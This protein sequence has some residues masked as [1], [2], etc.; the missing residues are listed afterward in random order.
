MVSVFHAIRIS[1]ES[2]KTNN[3]CVIIAAMNTPIDSDDPLL[4]RL[5]QSMHWLLRAPLAA[6]FLYHG[7]EKWL[8][9]IAG[10][11]EAVSLPL[12]LAGLIAVIEIAAG[13]G[14]LAGYWLGEWVTRLS[15][16]AAC[17]V[18]IGAIL[19]VHWGQWHFLPSATHP[20]GGLEFQV[21]LLGVGIYLMVRGHA[22]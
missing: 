3:Q 15:A 18:L 7:T 11:A 22:I 6:V 12:P 2:G 19:L 13:I 20:M 10:F 5:G 16:L 9:G 21:T 14:L 17:S 1:H 4:N 8:T